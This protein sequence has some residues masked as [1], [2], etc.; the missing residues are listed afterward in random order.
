MKAAVP[1]LEANKHSARHGS[2]LSLAGADSCRCVYIYVYEIVLYI[3]TIGVWTF[4][5]FHC[6]LLWIVQFLEFGC[7]RMI[8]LCRLLRF[9]KFHVSNSSE[10]VHWQVIT[11]DL[12]VGKNQTSN[13]HFS[14]GDTPEWVILHL[15][16]MGALPQLSL[17]F[18]F[19]APQR[20]EVSTPRQTPCLLINK[21]FFWGIRQHRIDGTDPA[22]KRSTGGQQ[23]L[24]LRWLSAGVA[25]VWNLN[26]RQATKVTPRERS[27]TDS[28]W[29]Y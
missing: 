18:W 6:E 28:R 5:L 16:Q 24:R 15:L 9:R 7:F 17:P 1:A 25:K 20:Q 23:Q 19:A 21:S 3:A 4:L 26:F 2:V 11:L 10:P 12:P 27:P 8:L 29:S 13:P 14:L 22:E